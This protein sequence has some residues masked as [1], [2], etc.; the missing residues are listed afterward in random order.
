MS[1]LILDGD[2]TQNFGEFYPLPYI[3]RVV[4]TNKKKNLNMISLKIT[5]SFFFSVP[6]FTQKDSKRNKELLDIM[7]YTVDN[8]HFHMII[9]RGPGRGTADFARNVSEDHAM[10]HDH[11]LP[12]SMSRFFGTGRRKEMNRILR[13]IDNPFNIKELLTYD[14]SMIYDIMFADGKVVDGNRVVDIDERKLHKKIRD[15]QFKSFTTDGSNRIIKVT[16]EVDVD[17]SVPT[18]PLSTQDIPDVNV[19]IFSSLMNQS[20]AFNGSIVLP[21]GTG[22]AENSSV[23][24][25]MHSHSDHGSEGAPAASARAASILYGDVAYE[26][27]LVGN[28]N[29]QLPVLTIPDQTQTVFYD[30]RNRLYSKTPIR[31]TDMRYR[32]ITPDLREEIKQKFLAVTEAYK[33]MIED[34]KRIRD[35]LQR[36]QLANSV[37]SINQLLITSVDGVDFLIDLNKA[38]RMF[39]ERSTGT[40]AGQFYE[41]IGLQLQ[42]ANAIVARNEKVYRRLVSNSKVIDKRFLRNDS[43]ILPK[44]PQVSAENLLKNFLLDR[45]VVTSNQITKR[46][47]FATFNVAAGTR[48]ASYVDGLGA[49]EFTSFADD[50]YLMLQLP[51]GEIYQHDD[52]GYEGLLNDNYFA[53]EEYNVSFGYVFF[54]YDTALR[55]NTYISRVFNVSRVI[56]F[57]GMPF[58]QPYYQ[59]MRIK[60]T[61]F[62]PGNGNNKNSVPAAKPIIHYK[63]PL[64]SYDPN[65]AAEDSESTTIGKGGY[66]SKD[67]PRHNQGHVL[68]WIPTRKNMFEEYS[69]GGVFEQQ[70]GTITRMGISEG[71]APFESMP[72]KITLSNGTVINSY[73]AQRAL[74]MLDDGERFGESRT[75]NLEDVYG[76]FINTKYINNL[77]RLMTFE[78]QNIDQ[79]ATLEQYQDFVHDKYRFEIELLD[80]TKSAVIAIIDNFYNNMMNYK[81]N[82][83]DIAEQFCNYN[84][85]DDTFNDFFIRGINKRYEF[86]PEAAP[87]VYG[88]SL[89]IKHMEFLTDRWSGRSTDMLIEAKNILQRIAPETG[90]LEQVQEFFNLLEETYEKYYGPSSPIG[91]F[92]AD[93]DGTGTSKKPLEREIFQQSYANIYQIQSR[94][95]FVMEERNNYLSQVNAERLR[96]LNADMAYADAVARAEMPAYDAEPEL[97]SD[98]GITLHGGR[99]LLICPE[100]AHQCQDLH[101]CSGMIYIPPDPPNLGKCVCQHM[102]FL[103]DGVCKLGVDPGIYGAGASAQKSEKSSAS[104]SSCDEDKVSYEAN[105]IKKRSP[106]DSNDQSDCQYVKWR[107]QGLSNYWCWRKPEKG[108][109]GGWGEAYNTS[110][111]GTPSSHAVRQRKRKSDKRCHSKKTGGDWR[112]ENKSITNVKNEVRNTLPEC[113]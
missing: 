99:A 95:S 32:K 110:K 58:L 105:K 60:L 59:P 16:S 72:D 5:Y 28:Y 106:Y 6:M 85:I 109:T 100:T 27:I 86:D 97:Q 43:T 80:G 54:D 4:V 55:R 98:S 11:T 34:E 66:I 77:Y 13:S 62:K 31:S 70:Y 90:T 48:F 76:G 53:Q 26:K 14:P 79:Q 50:D 68:R 30:A 20:E 74:N 19:Y 22:L 75:F 2:L 107:S 40:A 24:S 15:N 7:K 10:Y 3:D 73:I 83:L 63:F 41:D 45:T 8:Y 69:P 88:V 94:S 92:L 96:Y 42:R 17:F 108:L 82:Y 35:P 93:G 101:P 46:V 65:M 89:Y 49:N 61:K 52:P 36:K 111:Y 39:I 91:R 71:T 23:K 21:D 57:F 33:P 29:P 37:N 25:A 112:I 113:K 64:S 78:F 104:D 81:E 9:G 84:N 47:S 44:T 87:W 51:N 56:E 12:G 102:Y 38:R 1:Q 67:N 18:Y 103:E